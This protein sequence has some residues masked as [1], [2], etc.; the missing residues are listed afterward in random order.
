MKGVL[1]RFEKNLAVILLEGQNEEITIDQQKLPHNSVP[2]IWFNVAYSHQ[3]GYRII[4]DNVAATEEKS[5][6]NARLLENM[7]KHK[8]SRKLKK[9]KSL[10][11]FLM[12]FQ[13]T[14]HFKPKSYAYQ[15]TE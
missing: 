3:Y 2:S 13:T 7:Q 12:H 4:T 6:A 5:S 8:Q 11:I 10:S 14:S 15:Q 1:D 9:K